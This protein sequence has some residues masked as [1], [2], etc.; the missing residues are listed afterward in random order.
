MTTL[1]RTV[2]HDV[3]PDS[4]AFPT[5]PSDLVNEFVIALLPMTL[6]PVFPP[7]H[8]KAILMP[9]WAQAD[10]NDVVATA[11]GELAGTTTSATYGAPYNHA[12]DGQSVLGIP[13]PQL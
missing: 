9:R 6:L 2:T 8:G 13:L 4:H 5:R 3:T 12:S 10:P 7:R 11:T 1:T